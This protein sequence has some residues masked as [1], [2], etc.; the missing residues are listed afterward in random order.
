MN[1]VGVVAGEVRMAHRSKV[2]EGDTILVGVSVGIDKGASSAAEEEEEGERSMKQTMATGV[3]EEQR[4]TP[5]TNMSRMLT[6]ADAVDYK[7][8]VLEQMQEL[9]GQ[10]EDF[11]I[12]A[13]AARA[14]RWNTPVRVV[15]LLVDVVDVASAEIAHRQ[16]LAV[17]AVAVL[18]PGE[19]L[20]AEVV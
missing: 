12:A 16:I 1:G 17:E 19:A 13:A 10:G 18:V 15:V 11:G 8:A 3:A 6:A 5:T 14:H 4:D 20:P 7:W 2:V 9:G